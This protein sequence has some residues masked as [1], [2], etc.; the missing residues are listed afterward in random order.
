MNTRVLLAVFKRNLLA[1]FTSPTGYVFICVFVLLSSVAA[2][3]PDEFFNR[4]LANLD[5]LNQFFPFIM[6][7]FVPAITMGIWAEERRQGTDELLLT[8]PAS[9]LD[10]V[11]GKYLAAVAIYTV[12]LGFSMICNVIVLNTL[13]SPDIGLFVGTYV[14]YWL[15]GLA[16]LAVGMVASFATPNLT[17][18]YILG[19]MFNAP[20]V[21]LVWA[22]S[23]LPE[24]VG[25]TLRDW[26][27]TEQLGEFGRGIIS[28]SHLLYFATLVVVMLYLSMVF[29][30]ARHWRA[31]A[32]SASHLMLYC[33]QIVALLVIGLNLCVLFG[34]YDLRA[35]VTSEQLS[36]LSPQTVTLLRNLEPEHPVQIEAFISP[37]VPETYVQTRLDILNRLREIKARAGGKV[38]LRIIPTKQFS[39]EAARAEQRYG[40]TPRRVMSNKRGRFTEDNIFLGVAFTSGLQKVILPFIDRGI[41]V[42][43]ELVRSLATMTEQKRKKVGVLKTDAGLFGQMNMQTMGSSPNWP[44]V[45][46][47]EKQYEVVEVDPAAPIEDT[48]DVLLAVQPSSLSPEHME[49][50]LAVVRSGQPTAVFEDPFPLFAGNVPGTSAPKRPAGGP[51]A[52]MMGQRPE[53]KGDIAPLWNM[54]GVDFGAN[55]VVWQNYNPYPKL[56]NLFEEFVFIDQGQDKGATPFNESDPA[57]SG[58]HQLLFVFPGSISG[59]NASDMTFTPL[60][61]TGTKTGTVDVQ[62]IAPMA[63]FGMMQISDERVQ[64]P[65]GREYVLA[66]RI[67]GELP[68]QLELP[69]GDEETP[70]TESKEPESTKLD[71]ILVGDI[72][73]LHQAFFSLREQGDNPQAGL[74]LRFDN[75]TFVLNVLDSLAGDN[76]FIE[77][78][79]RRATHRTLTAIER[80]TE[81]SRQE[82]AEEAKQLQDEFDDF[83]KAEQKNLDDKMAGL[84]EQMSEQNM[85]AMDVITQVGLAQKA[86]QKRLDAEKERLKA[87]MESKKNQIDTRMNLEIERVQDTYKLW[88]VLLPPI[89]PLLIAVFVFLSRRLQE[90]EGV[91]RSRLR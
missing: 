35:D 58:L 69:G 41:P 68:G 78:R 55:N 23:I 11:L 83:V 29:I 88:A 19:A 60:A 4:N 89:L 70:D 46:E 63:M 45:A 15:V 91:S 79:N 82:T 84:K 52:M 6:L 64:T 30:S 73:M 76:R 38:I 71:V 36:S 34:R 47:L 10:V 8:I 12:S 27:I 24:T 85:G 20:L 67:E 50:F 32:S 81:G 31:G 5:Q 1:Y 90:K 40:I 51:Q 28:F 77:I 75:V 44:I 72:D 61:E 18:A 42:E 25:I 21:A 37:E 16:M 65:T 14:G 66:A 53:P 2:F 80:A 9:D 87:E 57:S 26:S 48:F 39:E 17:I 22:E 49:N 7:V 59:L 43:Y 56:S 74:D 62:Q 54:L 33:L 3:L 86:G 13:G